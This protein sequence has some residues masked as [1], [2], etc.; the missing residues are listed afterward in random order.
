MDYDDNFQ[1]G[2]VLL[3]ESE[4]TLC[5]GLLNRLPEYSAIS[6]GGECAIS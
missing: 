3:S 5:P 1:L 4:S 2:V 6:Q